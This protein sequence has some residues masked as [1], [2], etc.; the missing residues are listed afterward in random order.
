MFHSG[1]LAEEN[2]RGANA[3][4]GAP[5]WNGYYFYRHGEAR[6]ENH[7]ACPRTAAA[8]QALPLA[9]IPGHAPE[10]G[11]IRPR[12]GLLVMFPSYL[13]H[14]TVPFQVAS[15]AAGGCPLFAGKQVAG[16]GW[17]SAY[18]KKG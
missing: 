9:R 14:R 18:A 13:Y 3:Q 11:W 10:L 6:L 16:K 1:E 7:A 17:C 2:L 15:A 12:E 5:S 8:L 4:Y